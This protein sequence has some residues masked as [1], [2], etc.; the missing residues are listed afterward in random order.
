[1]N[2]SPIRLFLADD[3]QLI[4]DGLKSM[5]ANSPYQVVAEANNG[6]EALDKIA[7]NPDAF[8]ILITDISMPLLS[9]IEL[10][11]AV[12]TDYPHIKVL[13]LS[14]YSSHSMVSEALLVEADGYILKSIDKDKFLEA[15]HQIHHDGTY[16]SQEILPL[17]YK[18]IQKEKR[19]AEQISVL[20]PREK[21]VLQLIVKEYTSEQI[22][23]TLFISIKTVNHHR[24]S[25][26]AKTNCKTTIG[27]VKFAIK[28]DLI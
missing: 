19:Q 14:M 27:L 8:D 12:K 20:T 25:I 28:N 24:S 10:C 4:I 22:A 7:T 26:L 17:I 18:Q 5:L 9:G 16:F 23:Q 6:Q 1:M 13:I 11:K 15:L 21:E 3:H 2:P